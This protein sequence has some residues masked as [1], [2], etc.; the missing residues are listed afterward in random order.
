MEARKRNRARASDVFRA[1]NIPIHGDH[2]SS[3]SDS[4]MRSRDRD[5][6]IITCRT[7]YILFSWQ[8]CFLFAQSLS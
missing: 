4:K 7:S 5:Q 8:I 1:R 6:L 2:F 3:S